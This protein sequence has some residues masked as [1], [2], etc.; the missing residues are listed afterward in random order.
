MM[1]PY[2]LFLFPTIIS[3]FPLDQHPCPKIS[4]I[5]GLIELSF[6]DSFRVSVVRSESTMFSSCSLPYS[7]LELQYSCLC[8]YTPHSKQQRWL[9]YSYSIF[10]TV[11]LNLNFDYKSFLISTSMHIQANLPLAASC[12]VYWDGFSNFLSHLR[13]KFMIIVLNRKCRKSDP[14]KQ[15]LINI[16]CCGI[17]IWC[18]LVH[19]KIVI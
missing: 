7:L 12:M 2:S 16:L 19:N 13:Q 8:P 4:V 14:D 6:F 18:S 3:D 9:H 15:L 1:I 5:F 11:I 17:K 10:L